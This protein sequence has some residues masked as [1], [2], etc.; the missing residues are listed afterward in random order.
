V[1]YQQGERVK[2]YA[3]I[4]PAMI[5][6]LPPGVPSNS[7]YKFRIIVTER[8]I[9][10]GWAAGSQG[11]ERFDMELDPS[12]I[13]PYASYR[14]GVFS[15]YSV[16]QRGGCPSCGARMIRSWNPFPGAVLVSTPITPEMQQK[17][18]ALREQQPPFT[19]RYHRD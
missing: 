14:G 15:G 3:D 19:G 11:I 6:P 8:A 7:S 1:I 4:Y 18:A 17:S 12:E 16:Q 10:I 9:T 2:V 5:S 13:A